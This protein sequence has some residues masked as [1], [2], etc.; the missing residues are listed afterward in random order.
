MI[1]LNVVSIVAL[2]ATVVMLLVTGQEAAIEG[3]QRFSQASRAAVIARG[4]ELS[5]A[6][7]LMRDAVDAP[8]TDH[9]QEPWAQIQDE[10]V[11]IRGGTFSLTISDAQAKFNLNNLAEGGLASAQSVAL[12]ST[13]LDLDPAQVEQIALRI[14]ESGLL[15]ELS[16]LTALGFPA[17]ELGRLSRFVTV[18]PSATAININTAH[19]EL[20]AAVLGSDA[21]A[22]QIVAQRERAGFVTPE[23]LSAIGVTN[24]QGLGFTSNHFWVRTT[25]EIGDARQVRTVLLRRETSAE[26]HVISAIGRW[27]GE[28]APDASI[29]TPRAVERKGMSGLLDA[30]AVK[31]TLSAKLGNIRDNVPHNAP[32]LTRR[33]PYIEI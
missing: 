1:L 28:A 31:L 21:A 33:H 10:G 30:A 19:Q 32:A 8:E 22:Q 27:R 5:A 16:D 2:A 29:G 25:V 17:D 14:R 3:G 23:D 12:I 11:K 6:T 13:A 18:L 20:I 26:G 24:V 7:G 4:G 15:K 9:L